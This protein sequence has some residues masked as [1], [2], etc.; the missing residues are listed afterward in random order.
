MDNNYFTD[1][2]SL[3]PRY[4]SP[5]RVNDPMLLEPVTR[6][7]VIAVMKDAEA[8]GKP[9]EIFE[10]Y[11]SQTRQTALFTQGATKLRTVGV[12]AYGLACD[13]VRIVG[14]ELTW[15]ADYSFLGPLAKAH[16]LLWGG[17]WGSPGERHS[18]VDSDHVQRCSVPRQNALFSGAWYPDADYNPYVTAAE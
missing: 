1:V 9:I 16:G 12:H 5:L 3:D 15:K 8:A 4:Q 7:A 6:A 18:F 11:R 17:D 13:L 10:T 14:G 2:I